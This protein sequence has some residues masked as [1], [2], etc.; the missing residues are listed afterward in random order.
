MFNNTTCVDMSET[1][2]SDVSF[3]LNDPKRSYEFNLKNK[4]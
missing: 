1:F 3:N 2:H 4:K